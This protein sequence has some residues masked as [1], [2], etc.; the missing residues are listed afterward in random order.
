MNLTASKEGV[1]GRSVFVVFIHHIIGEWIQ[2][3]Y[4]ILCTCN[5]KK[6][7]HAL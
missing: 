1:P 7:P 6:D 3:I 5:I 4:N 2:I